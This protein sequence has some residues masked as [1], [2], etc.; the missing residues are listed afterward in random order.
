[1]SDS[2]ASSVLLNMLKPL[3]RSANEQQQQHSAH[4]HDAHHQQ[5]IRVLLCDGDAGFTELGFEC[6]VEF[7]HTGH[8]QGVTQGFLDADRVQAVM[9]AADF[10]GLHA[11]TSRAHAWAAQPHIYPKHNSSSAVVAI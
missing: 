9:Q 11:L 7:L 6:I 3:D 8:V 1:M 4:A 2:S 5:H 10:F